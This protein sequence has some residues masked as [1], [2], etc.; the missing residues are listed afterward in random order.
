MQV[1]VISKVRDLIIIS[2]IVAQELI[3][4]SAL[5]FSLTHTRA[6][7]SLAFSTLINID[8]FLSDC[9]SVVMRYLGNAEI[10]LNVLSFQLLISDPFCLFR[11]F[12][13]HAFILQ[14]RHVIFT[15]PQACD[16][17]S[18]MTDSPRRIKSYA[19]FF[20][21]NDNLSTCVRDE[22]ICD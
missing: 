3:S 15:C 16:F 20:R 18:I 11:A 13:F 9:T 4:L 12:T 19:S 1:D 22:P 21:K 7:T 14:T 6:H 10:R 5:P 17:N 8:A 2:L